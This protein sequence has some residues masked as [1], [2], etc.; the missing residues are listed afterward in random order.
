MSSKEKRGKR[1]KVEAVAYM[2]TSSATNVGADK[3]SEQR[4]RATIESYARHAGIVIIEWFYDPAASFL[5]ARAAAISCSAVR[6][7]SIVRLLGVPLLR[8]PVFRRVA[9]RW[10]SGSPLVAGIDAEMASNSSWLSA[11][12]I[13]LVGSSQV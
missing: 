12:Y 11:I 4:Q 13:Y 1:Q 3:D 10:P 7:F 6:S 2:R 9:R 5:P 8:P